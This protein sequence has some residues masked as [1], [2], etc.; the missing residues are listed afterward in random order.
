MAEIGFYQFIEIKKLSQQRGHIFTL[1]TLVL[2]N[3][4]PGCCYTNFMDVVTRTSCR[5]Q[6]GLG[7]S[8]TKYIPVTG[9]KHKR[10]DI[11]QLA[12]FM[13]QIPLSA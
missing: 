6:I 2:L 7:W 10:V 12:V 1:T 5:P 3:E 8:L 4:L 13:R 9:H 11:C